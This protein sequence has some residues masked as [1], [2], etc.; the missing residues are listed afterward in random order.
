MSHNRYWT[1]EQNQ[2][3][4]D[5]A[6]EQAIA[7]TDVIVRVLN[8]EVVRGVTTA[9]LLQSQIDSLTS[10]LNSLELQLRS[11]DQAFRTAVALKANCNVLDVLSF[12]ST[13][14]QVAAG[15]YE[16]AKDLSKH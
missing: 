4:Q 7:A 10:D 15:A 6:V 14:I 1:N 11:A 16:S 2:K 12:A 5:A 9:N 13:V 3:E 8:D